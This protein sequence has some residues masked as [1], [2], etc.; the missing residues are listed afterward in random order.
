MK[1]KQPFSTAIEHGIE[2]CGTVWFNSRFLKLYSF[3]LMTTEHLIFVVL[4]VICELYYMSTD[5]SLD[6]RRLRQAFLPLQW[7][8]NQSWYGHE[9]PSILCRGRIGK[10]SLVLVDYQRVIFQHGAYNLVKL[11]L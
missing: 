8:L 3:L 2:R 5:A 7:L 1:K 11:M 4:K 10:M 6:G 9:V